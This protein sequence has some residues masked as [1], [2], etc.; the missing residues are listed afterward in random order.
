MGRTQLQC[1]WGGCCWGRDTCAP[2]TVSGE[3]VS[4]AQM[5]QRRV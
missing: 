1:E 3:Q 4:A 5:L 2:Q